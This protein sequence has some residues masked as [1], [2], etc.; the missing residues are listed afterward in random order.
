[1]MSCAMAQSSSSI[2]AAIQTLGR[3]TAL[4]MRMRQSS[5]P[6]RKWV[7]LWVC[8]DPELRGVVMGVEGWR[9]RE[10]SHIVEHD[11]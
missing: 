3:T 11:N 10:W 9:D 8:R 6:V 5:A 2:S 4:I 7:G 1:M